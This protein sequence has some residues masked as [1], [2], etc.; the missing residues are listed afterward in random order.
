MHSPEPTPIDAVSPLSRAE[1]FSLA[2]L[3][4][5]RFAMHCFIST[6]IAV[7]LMGCSSSSRPS[8]VTTFGRHTILGDKW[9]IQVSEGSLDIAHPSTFHPGDWVTHSPN[10]WKSQAS[11]F[12]YIESSTSV[13]AYDGDQ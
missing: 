4:S 1:F 10:N 8:F 7:I 2:R 13:W 6:L 3:S 12:V 9:R 11:W 5:G